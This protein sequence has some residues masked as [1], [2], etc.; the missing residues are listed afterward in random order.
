MPSGARIA[1]RNPYSVVRNPQ[2]TDDRKS[3]MTR[4]TGRLFSRC[5]AVAAIAFAASMSAC[6]AADAAL[7]QAPSALRISDAVAKPS[8]K[9][10][11]NGE[12]LFV[13]QNTGS[14]DDQLVGISTP[15]AAEAQLHSM[16]NEN[17]VMK[18]RE[19]GPLSLPAGKSVDLHAAGMHLM[20]S[21][22]KQPLVVGE[23]F[24]I[25]LSFKQSPPMTATMTVTA[26]GAA[27]PA[28]HGMRG[29]K[30]MGHDTP[31]KAMPS[32]MRSDSAMPEA[33]SGK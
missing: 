24:P 23:S 26:P 12:G 13:I 31:S 25:T 17:G 18:M 20:L 22:L 30:G 19:A 10:V 4:N 15:A 29:M 8:L 16:K 1:A 21:G 3:F 28:M 7:Q 5:G 6:W 2:P 33:G 32:M 11:P 14:T 27:S 9:G